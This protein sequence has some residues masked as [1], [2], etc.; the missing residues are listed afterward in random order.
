MKQGEI[1][2]SELSN[3]LEKIFETL[4]GLFPVDAMGFPIAFQG[5]GENQGLEKLYS[6]LADFAEKYAEDNFFDR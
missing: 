4:G 3:D 1:S 5:S 6:E 2:R